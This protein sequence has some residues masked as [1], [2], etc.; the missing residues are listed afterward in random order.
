[1]P[2]RGLWYFWQCCN[3]HVFI[4]CYILFMKICNISNPWEQNDFKLIHN[5]LIIFIYS[6]QPWL[7]WIYQ[8]R[9]FQPHLPSYEVAR[10]NMTSVLSQC[11]CE[12]REHCFLHFSVEQTGR[13][14][15][16]NWL[17]LSDFTTAVGLQK[18]SLKVRR[19][20]SCQPTQGFTQG[21][22]SSQLSTYTRLHSR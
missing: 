14:T 20:H 22:T 5:V 16:T 13:D 17:L 1:M 19:H 12:G 7:S 8:Q 10:M 18:A 6:K 4:N 2:D 15:A 3:Q 11:H 9:C 21:K